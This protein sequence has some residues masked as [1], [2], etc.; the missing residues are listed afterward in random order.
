MTSRGLYPFLSIMALAAPGAAQA[1]GLGEIH[2]VSALNEPLSARIDIVGA[3]ADELTA[4]TAAIA[5]HDT[6]IRHHADRPTFLSSAIF[7]VSEDSQG[8]PVLA[9]S[10]G[11]PFT[12]PLVNFLVDVRWPHGELVR[13]YTLLLDPAVYV[14]ASRVTA[15]AEPAVAPAAANP[16]MNSTAPAARAAAPSPVPLNTATAPASEP[17]PVTAAGLAPV[18]ATLSNDAPAPAAATRRSRPASGTA[19]PA[20]TY[21]VAA[22]DTLAGIAKRTR[23]NARSALKR[24][25][26][27]IY[28]ANPDAFEGNINRLRQGAILSLPSAA[29]LAAITS[30]EASAQVRAQMA[31]WRAGAGMPDKPVAMAPARKTRGSRAAVD[32]ALAMRVRSLEL[33]I[34]EAKRIQA[35]QDAEL[36]TLQAQVARAESGKTNREPAAIAAAT[37]AGT[38]NA[39]NTTIVTS[40]EKPRTAPKTT[41]AV[42]AAVP[43]HSRIARFL[44]IA[45]GLGLLIFFGAALQWSR[46]RRRRKVRAV[47]WSD[48]RNNELPD[49]G[50]RAQASP[51]PVEVVDF[52]EQPYVEDPLNPDEDIVIGEDAR[53]ADAA[54]KTAPGNG[55]AATYT[56]TVPLGAGASPGAG[57]G[58]SPGAGPGT[59]PDAGAPVHADPSTVILPRAAAPQPPEAIDDTVQLEQDIEDLER[60]ARHVQM[61]SELHG[62]SAFVERR[63]N[64]VDVLKKAVEREPD[65]RDLRLKLLEM[66]YS[67]AASNRQAF[68]EIAQRLSQE[69]DHAPAGE[70]DKVAFMGRQVAPENP[71]FTAE[72]ADEDKLADC[73]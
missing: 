26:I 24:T 23:K 12:E 55:V 54:S 41:P 51:P 45:A 36:L 42:A 18:T 1:L 21:R 59:A 48:I 27:A 52:G 64:I 69:R 17:A 40:A 13:E 63:K 22:N 16:E 29:D 3:T 9:V 28:R 19:S 35:Q 5:N 44:A 53:P 37:F 65:R 6:F 7:K 67:A 47:A 62:Q 32:A 49:L 43:A 57:A 10:S 72:S 8:H 34:E 20:A 25:M 38:A 60:T 33:D 46:L 2:V 71:L 73:A 50:S 68:M 11:E 39:A 70:W 14:P 31:E 15:A 56:G 66:Y 4:L 30:D 58:P 61:P